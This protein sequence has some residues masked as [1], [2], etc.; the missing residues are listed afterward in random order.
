LT[1][2]CAAFVLLYLFQDSISVPRIGR[3]STSCSADT[4]AKIKKNSEKVADTGKVK[5]KDC[6][7][8]W[9]QKDKTT[10][11][12]LEDAIQ[13]SKIICHRKKEELACPGL[14]VSVSVDGRQVYAEGF[15]YSDL[16]NEVPI[17]SD[18]VMRIASISKSLTTV[19][20]AKMWE[21]GQ[22]DLDNKVQHYLPEFPQKFYMGEKVDITVGQLLNH[23]SGIR[24]YKKNDDPV[25]AFDEQV[26]NI[27]KK[28]REASHLPF[29]TAGAVQKKVQDQV[30]SK[31]PFDSFQKTKE[32]EIFSKENFPSTAKSLAL[33]QNDPLICKPGSKFSYTTHGF[34]LL[35][36][37][38]EAV[39]QKPF[40]QMVTR[41]FHSLGMKESY[42]DRPDPIVYK[43]AR[44]YMKNKAG[45]VLNAPYVDCSYKW[46]GGGLLST[47]EDLVKFGNILLYS[48]QHKEEDPGPPGYLKASTVWKFWSPLDGNQS[49]T[50]LYGLGFELTPDEQYYGMCERHTFGTGHTGNAV[51]ASSMLFILPRYS[52]SEKLISRTGSGQFE[53][54]G[55]ERQEKC[56][57]VKNGLPQGVVVAVIVNLPSIDLRA[58]AIEI[59][60][61]FEKVDF[62]L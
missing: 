53:T 41:T 1:F 49:I 13:K 37:V 33:F 7:Q 60:R 24:H 3:C 38:V 26:V 50:P 20:V 12:K 17:Q 36:A 28:T 52:E 31:M 35:S 10:S 14:V 48:A 23:T 30:E 61:T 43:R 34:T 47:T 19:I 62:S 9:G 21:S 29:Y 44:N 46:G 51:G 16:E 25:H 22:I 54:L 18:S 59:A 4:Q 56:M 57:A 5:E 8:R 15:G 6:P 58:T 32:T 40:A 39:A 55:K 11:I 42:L 45:K 27:V 2:V